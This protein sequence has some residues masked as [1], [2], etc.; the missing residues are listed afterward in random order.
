MKAARLSEWGAS[1][2]PSK[3]SK[4]KKLVK[5]RWHTCWPVRTDEKSEHSIVN[6]S[7]PQVSRERGQAQPTEKTP[8]LTSKAPKKAKEKEIHCVATT[9]LASKSIPKSH[10]I[11]NYSLAD[12]IWWPSFRRFSLTK[13][14][15]QNKKE[16]RKKRIH[17]Y[18]T[19][20]ERNGEIVAV[21]VIVVRRFDIRLCS[22]VRIIR[23]IIKEKVCVGSKYVL[24]AVLLLHNV[25]FLIHF[26]FT[27][28]F[29]LDFFPQQNVSNDF[30]QLFNLGWK[31][32]GYSLYWFGIFFLRKRL[33]W[34]NSEIKPPLT[35]LNIS[36]SES[37]ERFVFK[38]FFG[39][40]I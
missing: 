6:W 29:H 20:L 17:T 8:V 1:Q 22:G 40:V 26:W 12:C 3:N 31:S 28:V 4:T 16:K 34:K 36:K 11:I 18:F 39:I 38:L 15:L 25:S 37:L 35:N 9:S 33:G 32:S 10:F 14:K 13:K 2:W 5:L 24:H 19:C 23:V 30:S 27:K 21:F 7:E